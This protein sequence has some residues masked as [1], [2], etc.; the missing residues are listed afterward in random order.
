MMNLINKLKNDPRIRNSLWMLIEK[1]I[2]LFGLIFIISAVAKYTGPAIYGEISLAA[3]I[4]LVVKTI[5]QLGLD[6]IYFK[7]SSQYKPY[8][9]IFLSNSV[10]LVSLIYGLIAFLLLIFL[11]YYSTLTGFIFCFSTAIAYYFNAIDLRNF[12]FEGILKSKFNVIA[13]IIGLAIALVLRYFIVVF[14]INYF[15]LSIPIILMTLI[16][17]LIKY[18]S[19]NILLKRDN[20]VQYAN[21]KN[22]YKYL[23]YFL[24][25]GVPLTLSILASVINSQVANYI[26]AILLSTKEVGYYSIAFIL[27]GSWCIISTTLIMSFITTVY[28]YNSSQVE[29]YIKISTKI[30]YA[31]SFVSILIVLFFNFFAEYIVYF[32]YGKDYVDSISILKILLW[33]QFFWVL[34]YLFSRLIIKYNGY[35]FLAY[36]TIFS[37]ILNFIGSLILI[38]KYGVVGVAYAALI[39]E[40]VSFLICFLYGRAHLVYIVFPFL[41]KRKI[42]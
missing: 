31:I 26:I 34:S 15:Y 6:Q 41:Y 9:F 12:Y 16:P 7:Y 11:Y 8:N 10:K 30:F 36:K 2:S 19:Y 29:S 27:A 28:N 25:V 38:K 5:A 3:S 33:A 24:G 21:S 18:Y 13:N 17:F 23:K 35:K 20:K 37:L 32:L 14:K 40:V 39:S 42:S 4:F 1:G 22:S